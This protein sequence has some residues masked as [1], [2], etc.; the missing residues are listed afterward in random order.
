[1]RDDATGLLPG[2][3]AVPPR[4]RGSGK[5]GRSGPPG[6]ANAKTHGL[7]RAKAAV[8]LRGYRAIDGR[9]KAGK[10][11]AAWRADLA[12]DLGGTD[13]LSTQQR[14]LLDEAVKLKLM[15]DP[16]DAWLFAQPS[17]VDRRKRS[18]IPIVRER[19]ALIGQLQS[20]LRDL[21]LERKAREMPTLA[22]YIERRSTDPMP[23]R[24]S[25]QVLRGPD[26]DDMS[27]GW[28]RR[29]YSRAT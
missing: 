24:P 20:L 18:L 27:S 5:P 6:N 4:R 9:T 10:A 2:M 17:L 16:V 25:D 22:D 8:K 12:T 13:Q 29:R 26:R 11:L 28:L 21:G 1:M 7:Y 23:R 14:A 19:L 3:H 15:L